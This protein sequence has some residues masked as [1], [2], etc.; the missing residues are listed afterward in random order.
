MAR[1]DWYVRVN[2]KFRHLQLLVALDDYRNLS[3]VAT[4]LNVTQPA[5]SKTLAELQNGFGTPLFE[6]TGRGLKPT[7]YGSVLIRHARRLLQE[8]A[9]TGDELHAVAT[10]TARRLRI[11]TLPA[12]AAWLL[13]RALILMKQRTPHATVFVRESTIDTLLT[14]MRT[15]NLD[16][17]VGTLPA[18]RSGPDLEE[19][20]LFNDATALVV[21]PDHP[22]T[23]QPN[24]LWPDVGS[25][26]WVLPPRDSLLRQPLLVAFSAHGLEPPNDYVETLSL[27]VVLEL[28]RAT[29]TIATL[30]MS[31]AKRLQQ[32]GE[33]AILPLQLSRL[34]RPVGMLWLSGQP[35]SPARDLLLSCLEEASQQLASEPSIAGISYLTSVDRGTK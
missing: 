1:L 33:I 5:L 13:P 23:A 28:V 17:I 2:L 15:G 3:K 9:E 24:V 27:N 19:R 4:L 26:P 11:G 21:R 25:F 16:V 6:R 18:R 22:L 7:E 34:V 35:P 29:N 32:D 12:S 10:G 8:L 30:P 14:E 31:L 20:Q